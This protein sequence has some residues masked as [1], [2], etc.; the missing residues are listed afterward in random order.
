MER[1]KNRWLTTYND[2]ALDQAIRIEENTG[3]MLFG[4]YN[5][6]H[7]AYAVIK[8]ELEEFWDSVKKDDPDPKELLQVIATAKRALLELC[9]LGRVEIKE[10]ASKEK[11]PVDMSKMSRPGWS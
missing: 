10:Q 5:S 9:E 3:E 11:P 2:S 7:E 8:E 1:H 4:R 6:M